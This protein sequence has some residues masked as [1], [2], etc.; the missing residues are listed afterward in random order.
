M[1]VSLT[2]TIILY[3]VIIV[4]MRLMGKRQISEM[5]TSELVVTLL[6]PDIAAIPMQNT[7]T[8]MV[9]GFVPIIALVALEIF[10]S[11]IMFKSCRFHDF[12][13][14]KPVIVINNGEIDQKE[15]KRLRM[16]IPDL[17]EQLRQ[18]DIFSFKD[19]SYGIVETNG[20]L[21]VLKKPDKLE[22][23]ASMI[24]I[25]VPDTGIEMVVVNC[26]KISNF[27]LSTCGLNFN[28]LEEI[29]KK[30]NVELKDIFLM[31]ANKNKEY[32]IVKTQN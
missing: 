7:S 27:S 11:G 25:S 9:S 23:D 8:P 30:E 16:T 5:Q 28:W 10:L 29:L 22:V 14:G 18:L 31:T 15:M 24:E 32:N 2:R 13:C 20:K 26:G 6:I 1:M 12:V 4:A 17:A 19:V 3:L 21:S